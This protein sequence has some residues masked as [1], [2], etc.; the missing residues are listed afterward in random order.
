MKILFSLFLFLSVLVYGQD[1]YHG[2]VIDGLTREPLVGA[3]IYL[4]SNKGI[5]TI[6]GKDGKFT[7]NNITPNSEII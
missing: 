6:T 2:R 1:N 4:N 3:N 5:G 7:L